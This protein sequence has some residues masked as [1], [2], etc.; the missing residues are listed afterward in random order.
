L[1]REDHTPLEPARA[2][3][4]LVNELGLTLEQVGRRV[5]RSAGTTSNLISLL[6]LSEEILEFIERGQ[7]GSSHGTVL[8]MADD[9]QARA[10]LARAAVREGWT[11]RTLEARVRASNLEALE[12]RRDRGEQA[13]DAQQARSLAALSLAR[14]WGDLLGAEVHV[15]P[16]RKEQMRIEVAFDFAAEGIALAERLAAVTARGSKGG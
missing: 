16:M 3:A 11:R 8:L 5:G 9:L 1:A 12:S 7:L 2:G 6:K 4:T 13:Q 15:R 10:A 14:A